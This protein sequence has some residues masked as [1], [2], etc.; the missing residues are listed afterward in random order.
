MKTVEYKRIAIITAVIIAAAIMWWAA[1]I[2]LDQ[3]APFT[4]WQAM[5]A[6]ALAVILFGAVSGLAFLLLDRWTERIAATLGAWAS[7]ALFWPGNI[8]YLSA[9]PVFALFWFLAWWHI[10][11]DIANRQQ[12]H[13]NAT[14]GQGMK[15]ILFAA[16]LMVSLGFYFTPHAQAASLTSISRGMQVAHQVL[17]DLLQPVAQWVPPILALALFALLWSL[18]FIFREPAVWLG[19]GIFWGLRRIGFVKIQ[20]K[21]IEV[22]IL[23]L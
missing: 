20:K 19:T 17:L 21:Q 6:P 12:I 4:D 11:N 10:R 14:L 13:M 18:N 15:F 7:F 1:R 23:S 22:E 16:F 3:P 2:W 5:L 9:L 8:Y